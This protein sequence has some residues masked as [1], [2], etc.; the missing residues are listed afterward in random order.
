MNKA[1]QERCAGR[2][3]PRPSGLT[4]QATVQ[5]AEALRSIRTSQRSFARLRRC[6]SLNMSAYPGGLR[7]AGRQIPAARCG[8]IIEYG[9]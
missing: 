7:L 9:P 4:P 6:S 8:K 1:C 5:V 2:G 3:N